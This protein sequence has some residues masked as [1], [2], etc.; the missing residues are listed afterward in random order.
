MFF[1]TINQIF[2]GDLYVKENWSNGM[3]MFDEVFFIFCRLEK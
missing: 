3:F 2:N 1:I